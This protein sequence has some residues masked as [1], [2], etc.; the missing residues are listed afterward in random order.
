MNLKTR[1]P[2]RDYEQIKHYIERVKNGEDN[3]LWRKTNLFCNDIC[4]HFRIKI[5]PHYKTQPKKP[6]KRSKNTI[7]LYIAETNNTSFIDGKFI[8]IQG[9]PI[10]SLLS[11][12]PVG[13]LSGISAHHVPFYMKHKMLPSWETNI[14]DDWEKKIDSIIKETSNKNMTIISG[15][16]SWVQIYFEKISKKYNK[17]LLEIFPNFKLL[18]Y[19]GVNF[20]PYRQKFKNLIGG[21]V[22]SI[23][24]FPASEGFLCLSK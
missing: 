23:E 7:L 13:R 20:K 8:F 18:I 5:Y 10:L 6:S 17:N 1:V 19:G 2:I 12:I 16:P 9:S 4:Y 21:D 15:I 3:I 14:I 24:L 22:D 11:S